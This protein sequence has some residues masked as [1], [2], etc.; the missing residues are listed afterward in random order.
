MRANQSLKM[1][2]LHQEGDRLR[3]GRDAAASYSTA[4]KNTDQIS[5]ARG[6]TNTAAM[7]ATTKQQF[8]WHL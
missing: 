1:N 7:P 2:S 6:S 5:T 4:K 8:R 3:C